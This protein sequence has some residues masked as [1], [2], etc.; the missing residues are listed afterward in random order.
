MVSASITARDF[1]LLM[2]EWR[3]ADA[4]VQQAF[5]RKRLAANAIKQ[6]CGLA[7][8]YMGDD[9]LITALGTRIAELMADEVTASGDTE[10][11]R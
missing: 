11:G 9:K 5:A 7:G 4:V 8:G 6:A 2:N 10:A 3:E 1:A